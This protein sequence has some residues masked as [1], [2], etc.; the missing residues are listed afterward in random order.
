MTT[1][2]GLSETLPSVKYPV[3]RARILL[4]GLGFLFVLYF[5]GSLLFLLPAFFLVSAYGSLGWLLTLLL[6][7]AVILFVAY[8]GYRRMLAQ[9]LADAERVTP[10]DSPEFGDLLDFVEEESERRGM[11]PPALYVHPAPIANALAVGRRTKGHV[12]VYDGLLTTLQNPAELNAVVA[13]ELAHLDNRDSTAM[14]LLSAIKLTVVRFW[15]WFGFA[16]K[17]WMYERRGVVLTPTEEQALWAKAH[18]RSNLVCSPIGLAENSISRHREYIA[19]AEAAE[20]TSPGSMIG[21]LESIADGDH[22][23]GDLD[24]PQ[25]LCIHGE[26]DGVL[27]RLRSDHPPI[28]KRIRYVEKTHGD[29]D[30]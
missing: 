7:S 17:S 30:T 18:R 11:E 16:L 25:S 20:A 13:H 15:T 21:A 8:R 9:I 4:S 23:P 5:F 24:V 14:T 22:D 6:V 3:R 2:D 27:A 10:E 1:K 26:S 19:D 29:V 28:E 12:V